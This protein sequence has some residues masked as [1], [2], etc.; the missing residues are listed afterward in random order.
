MATGIPK[1]T[2]GLGT[3]GSVH[4]CVCVFVYVCVCMHLY[5]C[6]LV[7]LADLIDYWSGC[8][9]KGSTFGVSGVSKV[10]KPPECRQPKAI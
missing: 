9:W 5:V 1:K 6:V 3:H 4:V 10:H 8:C 2:G 7:R